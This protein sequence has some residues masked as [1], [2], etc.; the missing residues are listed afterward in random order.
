MPIYEYYCQDCHKIYQFFVRSI[1]N[2]SPPECPKCGRSELERRMSRFAVTLNEDS[3]LEKLADPSRMAGLDENDPKSL[4][5]WMKKMSR[6]LGEED[7]GPEFHEMID[8]MEAGEDPEE[9]ERTMGMS[10]G[11]PPTDST[12]YEA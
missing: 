12:L 8:R 1:I 6:E 11:M 7:L 4:A 10:G 9:I 2:H 5:R 3:R